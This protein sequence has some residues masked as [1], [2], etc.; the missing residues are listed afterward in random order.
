MT[1]FFQLQTVGGS[2]KCS[3]FRYVMPYVI[4]QVNINVKVETENPLRKSNENP[5]RIGYHDYYNRRQLQS[6]YLIRK[7]INAIKV[8][9]LHNE[10]IK[11]T[12]QS[13]PKTR[14]IKTEL[15]KVM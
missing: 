1:S 14:L 2:E 13:T 5:I 15:M 3:L 7:H 8:I 10:N 4:L 12:W 9:R 6:A 11:S